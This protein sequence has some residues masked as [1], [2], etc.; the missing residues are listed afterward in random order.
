MAE[1]GP[2]LLVAT[3]ASEERLTALCEKIRAAGGQ[4]D[5]VIGDVGAMTTA[6]L[7]AEKAEQHGWAVRNLVLNAGVSKSGPATATSATVVADIFQT[8]FYGAFYFAKEFVPGMVSRGDGC[9]VALTGAA[10][11]KGYKSMSAYCAS[12]HALLG[13]L[14]C[15]GQEVKDKGVR[16]ACLC[17][18]PVD[19][20]M[21]APIVDLFVKKGMTPA[22]A[23][24][25]IADANGLSQLFTPEEI[26]RVV[27]YHCTGKVQVHENGGPIPIGG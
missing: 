20:D 2:V 21:T 7:V 15:L 6:K 22:E 10:A 12:K 14:R 19:T 1:H 17:P 11:I 3:M 8:N 13:Y 4:A 9:V 16:V 26:A 27:M 18:G 25:K 23:K 24:K 5:Y